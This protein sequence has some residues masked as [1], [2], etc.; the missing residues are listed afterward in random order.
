MNVE[1]YQS[2]LTEF[3]VIVESMY[4]EPVARINNL[5][6]EIG[7]RELLGGILMCY[8]RKASSI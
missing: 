7:Y 4:A 3:Y 1:H 5:N 6:G 2:E 8:Y